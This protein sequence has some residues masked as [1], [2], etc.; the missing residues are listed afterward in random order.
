MIDEKRTV[1][2]FT[3]LDVDTGMRKKR[4]S[5]QIDGRACTFVVILLRV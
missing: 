2:V 3:I 5:G 1:A 4:I